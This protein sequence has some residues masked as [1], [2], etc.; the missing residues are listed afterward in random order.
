M[1]VLRAV[2]GSKAQ[3]GSKGVLLKTRPKNGT[4]RA[5]LAGIATAADSHAPN[6]RGYHEWPLSRRALTEFGHPLGRG[7]SRNAA[8]AMLGA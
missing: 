8:P 5:F 7:L 1:A 6:Y 2:A 4:A 3:G